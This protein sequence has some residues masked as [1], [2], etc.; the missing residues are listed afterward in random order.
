MIK[1]PSV[2]PLKVTRVTHY[3][4]HRSPQL[5]TVSSSHILPVSSTAALRDTR[6]QKPPN[7][8]KSHSWT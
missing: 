7:L 2:L 5:S 3:G 1:Y 8:C 4:Q 6:K